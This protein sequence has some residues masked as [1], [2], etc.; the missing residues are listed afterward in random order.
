MADVRQLAPFI[1]KWEGGFVNDPDDLGGATNMGV[2]IGTY[3]EYCKKKGRPTPMVEDLKDLSNE[4]W[5]DI[6]KSL[7]W[8]RWKA[9]QIQNQSIANILVD[10]V[11]ASGIYGIKKPQAV[12]GDISGVMHTRMAQG[13]SVHI[14]GLGYFRYALDTKGVSDINEIMYCSCCV[15]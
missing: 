4:E 5:T 15:D 9:D 10:W 13:K 12:L 1:L 7:Y 11:W 8:D 14:K 3:T 6:L 2:T